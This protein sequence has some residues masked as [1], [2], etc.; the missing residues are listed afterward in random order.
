MCEQV[1]TACGGGTSATGW[2][3]RPGQVSG[4]RLSAPQ[5][6][7]EAQCPPPLFFMAVTGPL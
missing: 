2:V 1:L 4:G 5:K 7:Q 3:M 6:P